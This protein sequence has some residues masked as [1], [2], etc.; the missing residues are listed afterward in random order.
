M[1][2]VSR[3]ATPLIYV[4]YR[5]YLK[6]NRS[7]FPTHQQPVWINVERDLGEACEE[8]VSKTLI[9]FKFLKNVKKEMAP[10]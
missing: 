9:Y 8:K 7:R 3:R 1:V 10:I 2:S 6:A 5:S 4:L